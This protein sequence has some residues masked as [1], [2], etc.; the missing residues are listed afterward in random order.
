MTF[1]P[2]PTLSTLGGRHHVVERLRAGG[3]TVILPAIPSLDRPT[4]LKRPTE[5]LAH[6]V[7]VNVPSYPSPPHSPSFSSISSDSTSVSTRLNPL[8]PRKSCRSSLRRP[9]DLD[10]RHLPSK[11]PFSTNDWVNTTL[12]VGFFLLYDGTPA[13]R[14]HSFS[15]AH[16]TLA[17]KSSHYLVLASFGLE[18]RAMRTIYTVFDTGAGLNLIRSDVLPIFWRQKLDTEAHILRL[19]APNGRP[20]HLLGIVVIRLRLGNSHLQVS[21]I[22]I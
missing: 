2:N 15:G 14:L 5:Q 17:M 8:L 11:Q 6:E 19:R 7:N 20:L 4:I 12:D 3:S 16:L 18:H 21:F 1:S 22:V 13:E 9:L 10:R